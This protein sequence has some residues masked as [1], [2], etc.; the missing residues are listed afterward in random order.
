MPKFGINVSAYL[1]AGLDKLPTADEIIAYYR[2]EPA[3]LFLNLVIDSVE[4][5][6]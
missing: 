6:D 5:A 3:D 2:E 4:E 1:E